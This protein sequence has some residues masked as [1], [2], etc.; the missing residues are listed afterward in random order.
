MKGRKKWVGFVLVLAVCGGALSGLIRH[1]SHP[2]ALDPAELTP[3]EALESYPGTELSLELKGGKIGLIFWNNSDTAFDHDGSPSVDVGVEVLLD[4]IWYEVPCENY[5]TAGVDRITGP[6]E[7]F[8][9]KPILEPYGKLPDGQYRLSFGYW[10]Y[11]PAWEKP[12]NQQPF[13]TSYARF[14]VTEGQY[15]LPE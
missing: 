12:L 4:G 1:T 9:A 8:R 3:A 11:D 6:G 5:A 15:A 10:K 13:Y 2:A 14:H 7:T